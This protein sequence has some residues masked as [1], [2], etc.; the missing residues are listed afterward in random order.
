[1]TYNNF[2]KKQLSQYLIYETICKHNNWQTLYLIGKVL[3]IIG[4]NPEIIGQNYEIIGFCP[5]IFFKKTLGKTL[6]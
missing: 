4:Q 1:M 6:K 3:E 5:I 2:L